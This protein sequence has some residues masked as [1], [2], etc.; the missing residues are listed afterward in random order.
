M[1]DYDILRFIWW[2]LL[3]ILLIGFAVLDGYDLGT[4]MLLPFVARTD[5]ERRQVREA[6]E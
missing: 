1:P 4:A 3:G 5:G 6:I 2:A